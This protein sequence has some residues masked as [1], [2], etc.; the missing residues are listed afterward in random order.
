MP[1]KKV[2]I[3]EDDSFLQ[4]MMSNKLMAES[5]D[6]SIALTG[7]DAVKLLDGGLIPDLIILDILLPGMTGLEFLANLRARPPLKTTPVIVFSNFS[8]EKDIQKAKE[9]GVAEYMV[10]ANF[11]LDELSAKLKTLIK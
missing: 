11:T 5:F 3:V 8:D 4:G 10:K 9:L 2:L 7:T 1:N 6:I